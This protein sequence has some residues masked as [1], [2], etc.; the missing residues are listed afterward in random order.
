MKNLIQSI[1]PILAFG[2]AFLA[3]EVRADH[4]TNTMTA[5][6]HQFMT[7]WANEPDNR[8]AITDEYFVYIEN[9]VAEIKAATPI[10]LGPH[11]MLFD[12][13]YNERVLTYH[14]RSSVDKKES[15]SLYRTR[16]VPGYS[17]CLFVDC[18]ACRD[19]SVLL[20]AIR[21]YAFL[22]APVRQEHLQ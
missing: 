9:M 15:Q 22:G 13:S 16:D 12:I 3:A 2:L 19:R 7:R 8:D 20:L 18:H 21:R 11:T 10:I 4:N 5:E 6:E 14:Y 1:I 17:H